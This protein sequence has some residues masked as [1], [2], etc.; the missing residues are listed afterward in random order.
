VSYRQSVP[1]VVRLSV[2]IRTERNVITPKLTIHKVIGN[3]SHKGY[4][5]PPVCDLAPPLPTKRHTVRYRSFSL[6]IDENL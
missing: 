2:V 5:C 4:V 6:R 1:Y 3:T